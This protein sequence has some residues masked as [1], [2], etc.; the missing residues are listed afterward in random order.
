MAEQFF[1]IEAIW[2]ESGGDYA[3]PIENVRTVGD[4]AETLLDK[5]NI[6]SWRAAVREVQGTSVAERCAFR[7][8]T[9]TREE[10]EPVYE[11]G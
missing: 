10:Y 4:I 6:A 9:I 7:A 2:Q 5:D 3:W 1:C 11:D 8:Q